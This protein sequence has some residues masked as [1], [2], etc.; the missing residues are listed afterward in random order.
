MGLIFEGFFQSFINYFR[1][2]NSGSRFFDLFCLQEP[3]F[4]Q[5]IILKYNGN[6]FSHDKVHN[7]ILLYHR[8]FYLELL[9]R[10]GKIVG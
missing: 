10:C 9:R 1:K 5:K 7:F 6:S 4:F 3:E 2:A 8:C